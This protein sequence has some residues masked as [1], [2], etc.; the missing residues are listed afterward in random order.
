MRKPF[1][2]EVSMKKEY[3]IALSYS[4]KDS[5]IEKIMEKEL[6]K[7]FA[8]SLFT[9]MLRIEKLANASQ[10]KEKLQDIFRKAEYS[11]ILYSK[12]YYEGNFTLAEMEAI[13]SCVEPGKEPH[14][15]IVKIN[16]GQ[17]LPEGLRG[18]TYIG[19]DV[20]GSFRE[21][22]D[23][24]SEN[25]AGDLDF[26]TCQIRR[27]VHDQIKKFM[28]DET[29]IENR[30]KK[31]FALN[32]HTTFGPGNGAKWN[33]DYDWNMLGTGYIEENGRN[34]R[35]GA[36]WQGLWAYLEKDFLWIKDRLSKEK[37]FLLKIHFNCHLSIAY[38]LGQFYGDLGQ[39]SEN[40]NLVLMSSNRSLRNEFPLKKEIHYALPADFCREYEGNKKEST[41]I[42]C[43]ISIKIRKEENIVRTVTEFLNERGID[44]HKIY[45][46]QKQ[47]SID[48]ADTLENM[49][50]YLREK[51]KECRKGH[52]CKIHLFPDTTAP[53]MFV[54]G[55]RA[56]VPGELYLYE[57]DP[58]KDSY[59]MSLMK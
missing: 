30:E 31:E 49:A 28:I 5:A 39:I 33:M 24:Y 16:D 3:K 54:L 14:F 22:G 57:Y 23:V 38:K 37:D 4:R 52:T 18:C 55:A 56:I 7:V 59:T 25:Y 32:I 13:R 34:L 48:C 44:C 35:K 15:F 58:Q 47:M 20:P 8:G 12:N 51:M 46:F 45:L 41:D 19:L 42:A 27:I 6:E 40:R 43:I 21:G 50:E 26:L 36:T 53:L 2:K 29:I 17:E 1:G 9:D 11:V 10:L